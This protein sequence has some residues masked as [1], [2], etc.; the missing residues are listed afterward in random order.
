MEGATDDPHLALGYT[1]AR[2]AFMCRDQT[3][4]REPKKKK[5]ISSKPSS[6]EIK[7]NLLSNVNPTQM[8]APHGYEREKVPVHPSAI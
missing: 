8:T 4:R 5:K 1:V 2:T 7:R 6:A 3:E